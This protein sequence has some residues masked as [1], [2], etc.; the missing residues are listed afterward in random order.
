M[1][2]LFSGFSGLLQCYSGHSPKQGGFNFI[3][4]FI[5]IGVECLYYRRILEAKDQPGVFIVME[6]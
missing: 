3:L 1:S 5:S 6:H 2:V 4:F